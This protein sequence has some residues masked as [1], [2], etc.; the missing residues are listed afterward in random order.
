[1]ITT[2]YRFVAFGIITVFVIGEVTDTVNLK[3][4]D[5]REV[6]DGQRVRRI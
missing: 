1:M 5:R 2:P 4:K 3:V 6:D